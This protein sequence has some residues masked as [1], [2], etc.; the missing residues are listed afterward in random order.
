MPC[1]DKK[2]YRYSV[3]VYVTGEFMGV[4]NITLEEDF[5]EDEV[6]QWIKD[7]IEIKVEKREK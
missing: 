4:L 3:D 2:C 5:T 1:A 7:S 6:L